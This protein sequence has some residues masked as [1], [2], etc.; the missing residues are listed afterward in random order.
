M[1]PFQY[2]LAGAGIGAVL[3]WWQWQ[4]DLARCVGPRERA[5]VNRSNLFQWSALGVALGLFAILPGSAKFILAAIAMVGGHQVRRFTL[6]VRYRIRAGEG[7]PVES[8]KRVN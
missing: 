3:A 4:K 1:I 2:M 7:D 6:M 5:F 8:A